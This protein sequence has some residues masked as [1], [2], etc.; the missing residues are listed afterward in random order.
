MTSSLSLGDC[1]ACCILLTQSFNLSSIS[2]RLECPNHLAQPGVFSANYKRVFIRQIL[3][4]ADVLFYF[5]YMR[6]FLIDEPAVVGTC[7]KIVP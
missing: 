2:F 7:S 4:A 5:S 3:K 6:V 1:C